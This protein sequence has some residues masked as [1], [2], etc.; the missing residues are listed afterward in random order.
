MMTMKLKGNVRHN[1]AIRFVKTNWL[2]L[3]PIFLFAAMY[4][5]CRFNSGSKTI[6]VPTHHIKGHQVDPVHKEKKDGQITP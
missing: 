2:M 3:I 6:K 4:L 5:D 1:R